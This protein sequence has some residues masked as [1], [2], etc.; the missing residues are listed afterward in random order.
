PRGWDVL[1]I[2]RYRTGDFH[3]ALA[4]LE[5]DPVAAK[6]NGGFFLAMTHWQLGNR[7]EARR[8][9]Q[10]AVERLDKQA[11]PNQG[12]VPFRHEAAKLLGVNESQSPPDPQLKKN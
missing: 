4:A 8:C 1:G 3:G 6:Q 2:A 5:K 7:D 9:Y 11:A 12:A 10:K